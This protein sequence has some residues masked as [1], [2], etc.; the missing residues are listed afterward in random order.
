[1]RRGLEALQR[2]EERIDLGSSRSRFVDWVVGLDKHYTERQ[3]DWLVSLLRHKALEAENPAAWTV[4]AIKGPLGAWL[5][6][7]E[8]D[9]M[10]RLEIRRVRT[11]D[12]HLG[13][14]EPVQGLLHGIRRPR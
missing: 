6:D 5:L 1:M 10:K 14:P 8:F 9:S 4:W 3:V 12:R 11:A 13:F 2:Y 7:T